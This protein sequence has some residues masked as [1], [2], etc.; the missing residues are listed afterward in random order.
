MIP[1]VHDPEFWHE[2]LQ[3]LLI[4]LDFALNVAVPKAHAVF[5]EH[6]KKPVNRPLLSNLIRYFVLDYLWSRGHSAAEIDP[7]TWG[8]RRLPN[9]GIEVIFRRSCIRIRKAL[10][11]PLPMTASAQDFYQQLLSE[12]FN[13]TSV[14]TNLLILWN[15][16][17]K[18]EYAGDMR[19]I[20]PVNGTP[21]AVQWDWA[22][23]VVLTSVDPGRV[24]TP[25][26]SQPTD[27]PITREGDEQ[28]G[29][30]EDN[31]KPATGTN[32]NGD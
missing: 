31:T 5:S 21:R 2:E 30:S 17:A 4:D 25:E 22:K 26:Y 19:L 11:P 8:M 3:P 27:L 32:G 14:A 6:L 10:E 28:I 18:L 24:V 29:A 23:K 15:L 16:N 20:R 13:D 7:D 12:E 9:N 1:N